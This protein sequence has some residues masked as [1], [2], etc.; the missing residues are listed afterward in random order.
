M[1]AVVSETSTGFSTFGDIRP[2]HSFTLFQASFAV[3][4]EWCP[5]RTLRLAKTD[6]LGSW[7]PRSQKRELGHPAVTRQYYLASKPSLCS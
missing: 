5:T 6:G 7:Y 3:K 2:S 1:E 4:L